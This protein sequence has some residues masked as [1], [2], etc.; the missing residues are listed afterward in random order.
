MLSRYA[1]CASLLLSM[2]VEAQAPNCTVG[3]ACGN[4]CI[5]RNDVCRIGGETEPRGTGNP[6]Q[7]ALIVIGVVLASVILTSVGLLLYWQFGEEVS[8]AGGEAPGQ[9]GW[10]KTYVNPRHPQVPGLSV[11]GHKLF[12]QCLPQLCSASDLQCY[13]I[14]ASKLG[15]AESKEAWLRGRGCI[16]SSWEPS[17]LP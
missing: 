16:S 12:W 10:R 9:T 1:I 15:D 11:E 7:T 17:D 4:A 13:N 14:M 2:R 3:I 6:N 8:P 5:S